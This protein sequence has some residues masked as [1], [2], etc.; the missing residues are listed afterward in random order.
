MLWDIADWPPDCRKSKLPA[1]VRVEPEKF[2]VKSPNHLIARAEESKTANGCM[3]R[4]KRC[5]HCPTTNVVKGRNARIK[6]EWSA[7]PLRDQTRVVVLQYVAEA[8]VNRRADHRAIELA[9]ASNEPPPIRWPLSQLSS[10]K[11]TIELWSSHGVIDEILPGEGRQ[12]S[13]GMRGP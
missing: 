10:M 5:I 13:N 7:A 4:V 3:R 12:I 6:L 11:R 9:I 1:A 2:A 8:T